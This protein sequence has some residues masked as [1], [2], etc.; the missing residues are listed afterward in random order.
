MTNTRTKA[1][2]K[3]SIAS[4]QSLWVSDMVRFIEANFYNKDQRFMRSKNLTIKNTLPPITESVYFSWYMYWFSDPL[5][6]VS[7]LVLRGAPLWLFYKICP[8]KAPL[9]LIFKIC[10]YGA[11]LWLCYNLSIRSS[12]LTNFLQSV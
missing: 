3:R 6:I 4:C 11:P 1:H 12:S 10:P 7:I 9:W 5:L 2:K 8:Y